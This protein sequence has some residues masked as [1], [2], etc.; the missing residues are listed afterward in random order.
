MGPW[1]YMS[2]EIQNLFFGKT[3]PLPSTNSKY[4]EGKGYYFVHGQFK[5]KPITKCAIQ[6]TQ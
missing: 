4:A 3:R 5:F 1:R 2:K 6:F